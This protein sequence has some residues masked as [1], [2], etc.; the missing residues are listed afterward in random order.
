[1]DLGADREALA[2]DNV[3]ALTVRVAQQCDVGAAV[4]I[5]FDALDLGHDAVFVTLEINHAIMLLVAAPH[6]A[7]GDLAGIVAAGGLAL[8]LKQC[9]VRP[10]FV[11]IGIDDLDDGTA[12]G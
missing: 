10:A 5:V 3:T 12:A 1:M 9:V 4:R 2:R 7:R 11:E 8:R 6:K